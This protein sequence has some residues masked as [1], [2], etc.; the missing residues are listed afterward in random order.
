[1]EKHR[2][3]KSNFKT[4]RFPRKHRGFTLIEL[5]VVVAIIA[6]LASMLLP[7]LSRSKSRALAA[8]DINNCKQSMLAM[9]MYVLDSGDFLPEPGW[10]MEYDNWLTGGTAANNIT[11]IPQWAAPHPMNYQPDYLAQ[12]NFFKG[13]N[14]ATRPGQLYQFLKNEKLLLCPQD[15]DSQNVYKRKELISSYVWDGAIVGYT[16]APAGSALVATYK[17]TRFKAS[18]I[19]QWEN[20]E[21]NIASGAWNDFSNF[22][23]EGNPAATTFSTRHGKEAQV[24]RMDGSAARI[25]YA[26]MIAMAKDSNTK[27]DLWY[28]PASQNGH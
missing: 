15:V 4:A 25:T 11:D 10:Q 21:N 13:L 5:L 20:D 7:A 1:V 18:N 3:I 2:S 16:N 24:G 19:L 9:S 26:E 17:L 22:P 8:N 12:L 14:P 27:N 6:I 23:M 28:S